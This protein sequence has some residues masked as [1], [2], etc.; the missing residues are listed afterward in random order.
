MIGV[1]AVISSW[2]FGIILVLYSSIERIIDSCGSVF[3][4]YFM[5]KRLRLSVCMVVA[6]L[7]VIVLVELM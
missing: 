4:E 3:V 5:S 6:I 7:W 2:I 1:V